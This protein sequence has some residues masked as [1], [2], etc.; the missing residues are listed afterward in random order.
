V[1]AKGGYFHCRSWF[2]RAKVTKKTSSELQQDILVWKFDADITL[3][4]RRSLATAVGLL[5]SW[6][7][8]EVV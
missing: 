7:K 5:P 6:I 1:A 4:L 2:T 3:H 8:Q